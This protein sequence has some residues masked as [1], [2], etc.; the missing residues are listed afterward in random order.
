MLIALAVLLGGISLYLNKDWFAEDNIQIYY[1]SRPA[2]AGF[3]RRAKRPDD[4]ANPVAFWFDRKLKLTSLK[5]I[6]VRRSKPTNIRTRSGA[7]FP[8]PILSLSQSSP[9]ACP[10]AACGPQ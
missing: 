3:F 2:R 1:R 8:I 5:V 7:W 4:S 6:P 10:F 9:T